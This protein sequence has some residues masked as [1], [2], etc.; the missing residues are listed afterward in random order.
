MG[1]LHNPKITFQVL[2]LVILKWL[3]NNNLSKNHNLN[4]IFWDWGKNLSI[5]KMVPLENKFLFFSSISK[6]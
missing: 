3:E 5:I 4:M 6:M 1:D 2:G